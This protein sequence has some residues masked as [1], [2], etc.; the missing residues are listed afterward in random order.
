MPQ[1]WIDSISV[2]TTFDV[3]NFQ[4]WQAWKTK[5]LVEICILDILHQLSVFSF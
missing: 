4:I 5:E 2:K 1:T 3:R